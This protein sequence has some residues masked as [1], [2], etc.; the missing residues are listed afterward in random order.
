MKQWW[1]HLERREQC[2]IQIGVVVLVAAILWAFVWDPMAAAREELSD[3]VARRSAELQEMQVH[4]ERVSQL[5]QVSVRQAKP[6]GN[7]SLLALVDQSAREAGLG[8]ALRRGEPG[9]DDSVRLWMEDVAFDR[10]ADWLENLTAD[11]LLVI[12]EL[13]VQ[14][15]DRVGRVNLRV[16]VEDT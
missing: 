3:T 5:R 16:T 4:A 14:R 12:R 8:D 11:Y 10:F 2:I 15:T 1:Q 13:N 7:R 9:A 6:R